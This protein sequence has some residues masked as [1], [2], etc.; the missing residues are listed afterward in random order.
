M[1]E[2][3]KKMPERISTKQ[4]MIRAA[5]ALAEHGFQY[6]YEDPARECF[7]FAVDAGLM[8]EEELSRIELLFESEDSP[9]PFHLMDDLLTEEQLAALSKKMN[10]DNDQL[11]TYTLAGTTYVIPYAWTPVTCYCLPTADLNGCVMDNLKR[12]TSAELSAM[13]DGERSKDDDA[14][15]GP[16][17]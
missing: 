2:F 16:H 8:T 12:L 6:H 14:T 9:N 7:E 13:P 10:W 1:S 11:Y 5:V 17:A 3:L 4:E 15:Q